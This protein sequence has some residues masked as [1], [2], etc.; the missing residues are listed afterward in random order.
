[1]VGGFVVKDVF[2]FMGVYS[3]RFRKV[4]VYLVWFVFIF[5]SYVYLFVR[6]LD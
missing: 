6:A 2:V 5:I 3:G 1:M 4:I